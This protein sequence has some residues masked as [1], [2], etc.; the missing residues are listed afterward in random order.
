MLAPHM[1]GVHNAPMNLNDYLNDRRDKAGVTEAQFACDIG[2]SQ[3]QV[4]RLRRNASKPSWKTVN[5][6]AEKTGGKVTANDWSKQPQQRA[7][8]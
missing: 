1:H 3:G 5:L 2:I 4:N 8:A 6:I 7:T